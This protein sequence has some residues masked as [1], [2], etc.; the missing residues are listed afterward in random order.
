MCDSWDIG[1]VRVWSSRRGERKWESGGE[2]TDMDDLS[3]L[4]TSYNSDLQDLL[5]SRFRHRSLRPSQELMM[6]EKG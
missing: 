1:M 4:P 5:T 2:W 6:K 3:H